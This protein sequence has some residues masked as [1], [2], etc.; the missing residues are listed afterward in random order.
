MKA[1]RHSYKPMLSLFPKRLQINIMGEYMLICIL[2]QCLELGGR[3]VDRFP[4]ESDWSRSPHSAS[5]N[6]LRGSDLKSVIIVTGSIGANLKG[7]DWG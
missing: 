2:F 4:V 1:A 6:R 3:P 5:H 7:H